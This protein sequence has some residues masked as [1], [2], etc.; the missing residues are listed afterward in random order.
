MSGDEK[1][2]LTSEP[3]FSLALTIP[4]PKKKTELGKGYIIGVICEIECL[5]YIELDILINK[6]T[7][8]S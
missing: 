5:C 1:E 2:V 3:S 8:V 4:E 6:H 7:F